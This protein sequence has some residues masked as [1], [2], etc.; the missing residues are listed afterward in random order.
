[1]PAEEAEGPLPAE[2]EEGA[3]A[4]W[5]A[6]LPC[7]ADGALAAADVVCAAARALLLSDGVAALEE[8]G[9]EAAA[10]RWARVGR[11]GA[12]RNPRR[13]P[14]ADEDAE[15]AACRGRAGACADEAGCGT[16]R[17]TTLGPA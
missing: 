13:R 5:R 10:G 8:A 11:E 4:V 17:W 15:K 14:E 3:P 7:A 2:E 1:M 6:L 16:V 12:P 9:T